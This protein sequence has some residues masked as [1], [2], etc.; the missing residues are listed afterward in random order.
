VLQICGG[1]NGGVCE[2]RFAGLS[3]YIV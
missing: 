2:Q 1:Y 3:L